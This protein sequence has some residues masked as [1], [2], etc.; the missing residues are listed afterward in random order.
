VD[1]KTKRRVQPLRDLL[2]GAD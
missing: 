1:A 2:G